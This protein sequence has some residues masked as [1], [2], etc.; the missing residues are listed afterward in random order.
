MNTVYIL[1][2]FSHYRFFSLLPAC[3]GAFGYCSRTGS[4]ALCG[5]CSGEPGKPA[6]PWRSCALPHSKCPTRSNTPCTGAAE[7]RWGPC[8][9]RLS[10][11]TWPA[12]AR[13]GPRSPTWGPTMTSAR[14][15]GSPE[16]APWTWA[17]QCVRSEWEGWRKEG[18]GEGEEDG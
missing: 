1:C 16:V 15:G 2:F 9:L 13:E 5:R 4:G 17:S 11:R 7:V 8:R 3:R 14:C 6:R 18:G 12:T 10:P